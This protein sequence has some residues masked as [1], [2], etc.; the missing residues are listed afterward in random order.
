MKVR[1]LLPL[2]LLPS[3]LLL[4]IFMQPASA[5]PVLLAQKTWGGL[6]NDFGRGV[7]VDADSGNIYVTGYTYS[8]GLGNPTH[9]S[10]TLLKYDPTGSL[11]W[12]R[13][14]SGS[15]NG[16]DLGY[17]VAVDASGNVYVT[18]ATNSFGGTGYQVLLLKFDSS[19][20]LLW[21]KTVGGGGS[22][23]FYGYAVSVGPSSG[24]IYVTGSFTN[25]ITAQNYNDVLL[26]KFDSSG[27][28]LFEKFWGGTGNDYGYGVAVDSSSGNVYVTGSTNSFGAGGPDVFLL[29][30]TSSGSLIWQKTWG[31]SGNDYGYG[32]AVDSS[33][34]NVYVTG[35]TNSF[36]AGFDDVFLLKFDSTS[37]LL[38]QE[39]WGGSQD[40]LG[41][42]V[43]VDSSSGNVYV[44]GYTWSFG[45]G[46]PDVMLLKFNAS[47]SLIWQKTWGGSDYDYGYGVAVDSRGDALVAGFVSE[48]PPYTLGSSGN[49]TLG[50][51]SFTLGTP[52][53]SPPLGP[54]PNDFTPTGIVQTPSG[55]TSYAGNADVFLFEYGL[56]PTITFQTSPAVGSLTFN[57]TTYTNGQSGNFTYGSV[58]ISA[59]PPPGYTFSSWITT[60]GITLASHITNPTTATITGPGTLTANFSK[61]SPS[62]YPSGV[63]LVTLITTVTIALVSRRR[64]LT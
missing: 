2:I 57:G 22:F 35:S 42:G 43:A 50:I 5:Q 61:T 56:L 10:L 28:F 39:T 23:S 1:R 44:T 19:G 33:S 63:L 55:S 45:A 47:G 51:P 41:Y 18:G 40:D 8:F 12:Q 16:N 49:N 26:L 4:P 36:G 17:G 21:Q 58:P 11:L 60:G 31:D 52:N 62:L 14:W 3:L 37:G 32:V 30:Y 25:F 13:I 38:W 59:H 46:G 54:A 6:S 64:R 20:S 53:L 9:A 34:G 15:G 27:S 48:A 7:A 24:N 29:K